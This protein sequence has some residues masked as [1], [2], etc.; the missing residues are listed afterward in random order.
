MAVF[1]MPKMGFNK[2]VGILMSIGEFRMEDNELIYP[3]NPLSSVD[4]EILKS[5]G[6]E[7]ADI[8]WYEMPTEPKREDHTALFNLFQ[9][10]PSE[11]FPPTKNTPL[12]FSFV[13]A[14][15]KE[16]IKGIEELGYTINECDNLS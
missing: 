14:L 3:L 16:A 9:E 5:A 13:K 1:R 2:S 10:T 12:R 15:N 7:R 6:F 8:H 11:T 4:I